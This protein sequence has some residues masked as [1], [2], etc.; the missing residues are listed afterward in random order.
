M[1]CRCPAAQHDGMR[2][3]I[4]IVLLVGLAAAAAAQYKGQIFGGADVTFDGETLLVKP[5]NAQPVRLRLWGIDTSEM[6]DAAWGQEARGALSDFLDWSKRVQCLVVD[7]DKHKRPVARCATTGPGIAGGK[8]LAVWLL[9]RGWAVAD[10]NF[11]HA[12]DADPWLA[13][14]YDDAERTARDGRL[15]LWAERPK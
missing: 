13:E 11:T 2:N 9:E 1:P 15:G 7:H 10:R 12:P 14:L 5:E 3:F 4:L 6:K 8:D